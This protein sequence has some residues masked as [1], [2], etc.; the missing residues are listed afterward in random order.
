MP[1]LYGAHGDQAWHQDGNPQLTAYGLGPRGAAPDQAPHVRLALL[2]YGSQSFE[3]RAAGCLRH[4]G[5]GDVT[6]MDHELQ[7]PGSG[8]EKG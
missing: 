8:L 3:A 5:F 6:R 1:R 7:A 2:C 4:E